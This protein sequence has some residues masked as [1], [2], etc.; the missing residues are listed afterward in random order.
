MAEL[1]SPSKTLERALQIVGT[2]IGYEWLEHPKQSQTAPEDHHPLIHCW[3][4]AKQAL[5]LGDSAIK[6]SEQ[7][8]SL[9]TL[10]S[11]LQSAHRH[12]V[13]DANHTRQE[14]KGANTFGHEFYV[15]QVADWYVRLGCDE[16]KTNPTRHD[17][18]IRV[19]GSPVYV[20]CKKKEPLSERDIKVD[21][22][23][24]RLYE[25]MDRKMDE[26]G[27]NA[28]VWVDAVTDPL[29][30]DID[31]LV[32]EFGD[33]LGKGRDITEQ[34]HDGKYTI[35]V[36]LTPPPGEVIRASGLRWEPW[37]Q[38]EKGTFA[39]T[40]TKDGPQMWDVRHFL[41]NS[42][43]DRDYMKTVLYSLNQASRQLPK[44]G[45]GIVHIDIAQPSSQTPINSRLSEI[46][47]RLVRKLAGIQYR[48][49][50][51]VVLSCTYFDPDKGMVVS[52]G[53]SLHRNP[54]SLLPTG[55]HIAGTPN[56][57]EK[58]KLLVP[59]L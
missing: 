46:S 14:L 40:V 49:I 45:P 4:G 16:V 20:E 30:A 32:G 55:F 19:K 39:V 48:R 33:L 36:K 28:I 7:A 25:R 31:R 54:R 59:H 26:A 51:A 21:V 53:Q 1:L 12:S 35:R 11:C 57:S 17:I 3:H 23:W 8:A 27:V 37:G 58:A 52:F 56:G 50:N 6:E 42:R 15:L 38:F 34:L 44:E 9:I 18:T 2:F 43:E 41:F 24:G 47:Q 5:V 10:A 22:V 29:E 13:F